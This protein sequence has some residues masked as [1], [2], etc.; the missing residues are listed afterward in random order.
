MQHDGKSLYEHEAIRVSQHEEHQ[1]LARLRGKPV[2]LH[3]TQT[4]HTDIRFGW[5]QNQRPTFS[6]VSTPPIKIM[7][8][9]NS[10]CRIMRNA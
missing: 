2:V 6:D 10:N 5:P 9:R 3:R 1:A 4:L 8:R 7:R